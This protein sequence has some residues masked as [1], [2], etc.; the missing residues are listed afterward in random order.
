MPRRSTDTFKA[1]RLIKP[2][3]WN[4]VAAAIFSFKAD[5][6]LDAFV[7]LL[8]DRKESDSITNEERQTLQA[9]TVGELQFENTTK[10]RY[11]DLPEEEN[12]VLLFLKVSNQDNSK[13]IEF[14]ARDQTRDEMRGANLQKALEAFRESSPSKTLYDALCEIYIPK[15]FYNASV[16]KLT[17]GSLFNKD[18]GPQSVL[19]SIFKAPLERAIDTL[20]EDK[21]IGEVIQL[22]NKISDVTKRSDKT[23]ELKEKLEKGLKQAFDSACDEENIEGTL[24]RQKADLQ[25]RKGSLE[26]TLALHTQHAE[27]DF[28]IK[29]RAKELGGMSTMLVLGGLLVAG[30]LTIGFPPIGLAIAGT[31]LGLS[32]IGGLLTFHAKEKA[33]SE[34]CRKVEGVVQKIRPLNKKIN[35]IQEDLRYACI[36]SDGEEEAIA[37]SSSH[38]AH[39]VFSPQVRQV[40]TQD[41][42]DPS[43][44]KHVLPFKTGAQEY[45]GRRTLRTDFFKPR[46]VKS[47][48]DI[49][50]MFEE[51]SVNSST[52][53]DKRS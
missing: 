52:L 26:E 50:Q 35:D 39:D 11:P 25:R 38:E 20:L 36:P 40:V 24:K 48:S 15:D 1:S 9:M 19:N 34:H 51:R 14:T 28:W 53:L 49:G 5:Q 21:T 31:L 33:Y 47:T 18:S 2:V 27:P 45:H 12:Q 17:M 3:D 7:D 4:M 32:F 43:Q 29:R 10:L 23:F 8:F 44:R 37:A 13:S 6:T 42:L 41:E 46:R 16:T 30:A 22:V